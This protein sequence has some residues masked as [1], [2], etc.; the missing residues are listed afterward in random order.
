MAL[1]A[2]AMQLV[3]EGYGSLAA[4]RKKS[5]LEEKVQSGDFEINDLTWLAG[6]YFNKKKYEKGEEYALKAYDLDSKQFEVLNILFKI[7]FESSKYD[8]ALEIVEA[9]IK[10]LNRDKKEMAIHYFNC[11]YCHFK[12][13]D[14]IKANEFKLKA[15]EI[16]YSIGRMKYK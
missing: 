10:D 7:Y 5:K 14:G 15:Q 6:Y 13:G 1:G 16:D 12:L 8:K 11:G 3:G 4:K 9:I 2:L